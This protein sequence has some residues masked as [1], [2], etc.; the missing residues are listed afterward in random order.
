MNN[1]VGN[2]RT[3]AADGLRRCADAIAALFVEEIS[4]E[5]A[6]PAVVHSITSIREGEHVTGRGPL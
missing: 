1:D 5:A 2:L 6:W 4:P 3:A